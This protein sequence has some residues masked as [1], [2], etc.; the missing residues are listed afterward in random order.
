MSSGKGFGKKQPSR[1]KKQL[2]G[3]HPLIAFASKFA[4]KTGAASQSSLKQFLKDHMAQISALGWKGYQEQGRGALVITL[5]ER[6]FLRGGFQVE[7]PTEYVGYPVEYIDE[8][9]IFRRELR[10][11]P[12]IKGSSLKAVSKYDPERQVAL[13]F[14][15][16]G[17]D[18]YI[19]LVCNATAGSPQENYEKLGL[20]VENPP[21]PYDKLFN[22]GT[23]TKVEFTDSLNPPHPFHRLIWEQW[24]LLAAF[25]WKRYL[26]RGRGFLS[27]LLVKESV[28]VP[29]IQTASSGQFP[30][31]YIGERDDILSSILKHEHNGRLQKLIAEYDPNQQ[32]VIQL[33]WPHCK[34]VVYLTFGVPEMPP[35]KCYD[36]LKGQLEEFTLTNVTAEEKTESIFETLAE[37]RQRLGLPAAGS[38]ADKSTIAKLELGGE[39]FFGINSGSNPNPR[40]ITFKV[41]PITKT[42]AEADAFQQ[43]ADAGIRGG[44]ARLIVDRDLCD[45]CGLRGGVNSM[46]WQLGI[47]ELEIITP[48]GS[49]TITVKPPNR[50]RQ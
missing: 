1:G 31:K 27:I 30:I 39:S 49:K 5:D 42:H 22:L 29:G 3:I 33:A 15:W 41:N 20:E 10:R 46:A 36:R 6:L 40:Q 17:T 13:I 50:R 32:I 47:E 23:G 48:S 35:A 26:E 12:W 24:E 9:E 8:Q 37:Y 16:K 18:E 19:S 43:A 38:E 28:E 34:E 44:K 2:Q 11:G 7:L 21:S 45:A 25:A 4:S 14:E